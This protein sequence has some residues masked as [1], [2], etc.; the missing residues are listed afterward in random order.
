ML[1]NA[2]GH[3]AI[4]GQILSCDEVIF[5]QF[6]DCPGYMLRFAFAMEWYPISDI[7]LDLLRRQVILKGCANNPRRDTI[8]SDIVVCEFAGKG[9]R[10]LWQGSLRHPVGHCAEAA[11]VTSRGA[12][13]YDCPFSVLNHMRYDSAGE[14]Q[15]G[16]HMDI[17]GLNPTLL[18]HVKESALDYT[19]GSMH[20]DIDAPPMG[21]RFSNGARTIFSAACVGLNV[22]DLGAMRRRLGLQR[23]E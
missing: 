3:T 20:Q 16:M 18:G 10:K 17:E 9:T 5:H 6:Q 2:H 13:E 4:D 14:S 11:T 8:H 7:V 1:D 22:K 15:H 23:F 12:D 21:I 19:A